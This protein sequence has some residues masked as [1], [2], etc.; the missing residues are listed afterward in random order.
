MQKIKF[1]YSLQ[2]IRWVEWHIIG[3]VAV[4]YIK[5]AKLLKL[6]NNQSKN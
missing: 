1:F 4:V 3:K 6:L 2:R 5:I